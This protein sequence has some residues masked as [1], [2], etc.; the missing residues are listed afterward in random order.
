MRRL[1]LPVTA[2]GLMGAAALPLR[3]A[4]TAPATGP[5]AAVG[6]NAAPG[7]KAY[8]DHLR[9]RLGRD[10]LKCPFASRGE[11][12]AALAGGKADIARL[13]PA[14]YAPVREQTR[15][16]LTVRTSRASNRIPVIV[17]VRAADPA[18][19]LGGLKGR[20]VAFGSHTPA[21]LATPR[22]VLAER[23]LAAGAYRERVAPDGDAAIA[24]VRSRSADAVAVHAAAWQRACRKVTPKVP[25]PCQ[26][27]RIL[28]KARPQAAEAWVVRR[29]IPLELR[30]RLIGI[31]MPLHLEAP[32]AFAFAAG[33][34]D[35][36]EFQPAEADALT[37]AT[38]K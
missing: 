21:G 2:V 23:G 13:D 16:L 31:H 24:A 28:V 10:V 34:P 25:N 14:A 30:Y 20:L 17:A 22:A 29:D 11:A 18:R 3:I 12:A 5:C 36:A 8:Y 19:D 9:K 7:E 37:L 15:A 33:A 32:A 27:L 38:L 6:G 35:A 26:D 1:L 4:V